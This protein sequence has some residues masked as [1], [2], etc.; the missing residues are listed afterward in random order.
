MA[1]GGTN[2]TLTT[3][4][5][6]T[7]LSAT[8]PSLAAGTYDVA[9]LDPA[10]ASATLSN[11]FTI[12]S[13]QPA[14][15][16]SLL[17][18]CTVDSNNVPSCSIPS[19]WTLVRAEGFESGALGTGEYGRSGCNTLDTVSS[20]M[21]HT[22][23]YSWVGNVCGDGDDP[24]WGL[25]YQQVGSFNDL[26]VSS[27]TYLSPGAHIETGNFYFHR[28]QCCSGNF[29]QEL[30][31]NLDNFATQPTNAC[32][33]EAGNQVPT[34]TNPWVD[35]VGQSSCYTSGCNPI[36]TEID[37]SQYVAKQ[38]NLNAGFWQQNETW[39]HFNA[40]T[41]NTPGRDGFYKFYINGRLLISQNNVNLIGC[42]P[43]SGQTNVEVGGVDTVTITEDSSGNCVGGDGSTV[44]P[45]GRK[46]QVNPFSSAPALEA[47]GVTPCVPHVN[48]QQYSDDIVI[49]SK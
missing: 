47:D 16:Q 26:Y 15:N 7:Q 9:V 31:V 35:F 13:P 42:W 40:C 5:S 33:G 1:F 24:T 20:A 11:A 38:W 6:G 39:V 21:A 3:F 10:P 41:H 45:G 30:L 48:I 32:C 2:A 22:G 46:I 28:F 34:I 44:P 25:A 12:T 14:G 29:N 43:M 36:G 17:S 18:G 19:G 4:V 27:W 37:F 49:L 8:V 23:T